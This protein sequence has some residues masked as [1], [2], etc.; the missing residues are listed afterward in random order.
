MNFLHTYHKLLMYYN[1]GSLSE[2]GM[3]VSPSF[4]NELKQFALS[5]GEDEDLVDNWMKNESIHGAMFNE[6]EENQFMANLIPNYIMSKSTPECE[7]LFETVE[8]RLLDLYRAHIDASMLRIKAEN[9]SMAAAEDFEE[10]FYISDELMDKFIEWCYSK[11]IFDDKI[12]DGKNKEE[13]S[14]L[15]RL[16]SYAGIHSGVGMP[17]S[18]TIMNS[19]FNYICEVKNIET[20]EIFLDICNSSYC[21]EPNNENIRDPQ[22]PSEIEPFFHTYYSSWGEYCCRDEE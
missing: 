13:I 16:L 21:S 12:F 14:D 4:F 10:L 5:E 1:A 20:N 2:L 9:C 18:E 6:C 17:T 15:L 7:L 22:C 3:K 8:L 19:F 11:K